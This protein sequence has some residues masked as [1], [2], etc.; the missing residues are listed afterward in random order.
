MTFAATDF[1]WNLVRPPETFQVVSIHLARRGPALGTAKNNH[2][3]AW[4][5]R[6]AATPRLVLELADRK[7]TV[8]Q[9]GGHLLVHP[10]RA[11]AFH[12]Q[13][14]IPLAAKLPFK[15]FMA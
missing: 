9:R 5:E 10:P 2:G 7:Y 13:S 1:Q 15:P 14:C 3:P 8:F 6:L 11:T 4:P 12:K